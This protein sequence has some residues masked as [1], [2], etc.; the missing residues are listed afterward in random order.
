MSRVKT[1]FRCGSCG[2]GFPKW[3]GRCAT[4]GEWNTLAEELDGPAAPARGVSPSEPAIL[5]AN[6]DNAGWRAT[7]TGIGELDRVL[8]GGLVP[9]SVTLLGGEPGIG[10]STLVVQLLASLARSGVR[11]LLISG[12]ESL[13]QVRL[14][15]E[16]LD[17]LAPDLWLASETSLPAVI[18]H[19]D[20]VGPQVVVIDSIQTMAD[21]A[22]ASSPGSVGQVRECAHAL[23]RLAKDRGVTVVLIGH[24]TK[25]GALAGPRVLEHVVDTVLSFEGDRYHALRMLRAV[26]HRFGATG[27]LGLFEMLE[28]GLQGVP[29]PAALFLGDRHV[30][31][32]GSIVT[33]AMEGQRPL[34]VET[35]ALVSS[36]ALAMPRRNAQGLDGNRL[37][38]LTAVLEQRA[39]VPLTFCDVFASVVGG[40]RVTEPASDLALALAVAS[41]WGEQQLPSD[42]VAI[43]EIGLAGE[44]RSVVHLERRLAEA[45]RLGFGSAVVPAS[46]PQVD[47]A[48]ELIRVAT[49]GEAVDR[50]DLR[51][52]IGMSKSRPAARGRGEGGSAGGE[53][54]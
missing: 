6:V 26:K 20:A 49:L 44:V 46:A 47:V 41:A 36:S 45:A 54:G 33:C 25:E 21:P 40:V 28:S 3:G 53:G 29:D 13:Q 30:G 15:A 50:F 24:V 7:P 1:I 37:S 11:S 18:G 2:A 38:L 31:A 4:C 35:Q 19:I 32:T 14:R 17:A 12:E 43:G 10:K 5:I 9:G 23:V 52:R 27:E 8:G 42:L 48:I 16:R 51:T 22:L 39:Q 34:L